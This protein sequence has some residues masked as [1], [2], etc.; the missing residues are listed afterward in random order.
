M[1]YRSLN[2]LQVITIDG[3]EKVVVID[4]IQTI[5][6]INATSSQLVLLNE[7]VSVPGSIAE[8]VATLSSATATVTDVTL[9]PPVPEPEVTSD[10]RRNNK[11][12]VLANEEAI[13]VAKNN[14][15]DIQFTGYLNE[16][17]IR[18]SGC[19]DSETRNIDQVCHVVIN[20]TSHK[21]RIFERSDMVF[22]F[23]YKLKDPVI[24]I[25]A[26]SRKDIDGMFYIMSGESE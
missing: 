8:W 10:S 21:I 24:R 11:Y 19:E 15:L 12:V 20:G 22:N 6:P 1:S 4:K 18:V 2:T 17:L 3:D 16:V 13:T 14:N 26:G 25:V 9:A 7:R 5:E 23:D